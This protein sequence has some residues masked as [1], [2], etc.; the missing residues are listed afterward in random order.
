MSLNQALKEINSELEG[1]L[2]VSAKYLKDGREAEVNGSMLFPT[3]SV[4]KVPLLIE[5]YRQIEQ[6]QID[7]N[8]MVNLKEG[9]KVPGS[10]ILK[11]LEEGLSISVSDLSTLMMIVSD[12]TA[13]DI[14]LEKVGKDNVNKMLDEFGF[15]KT[16]VV[17]DCRD[18]LFDLVGL[19]D[20]PDK[21][22]TLKL[23]N[24]T[25]TIIEAKGSWS[26]GIDR[27]NVTTPVEMTRLLELIVK[28]EAAS[29]D[30]CNA[31]LD[32]MSKCQTGQYRIPKYLPSRDVKIIHKTGSLPGIRNDVGIVSR[33]DDAEG[34]IISCFTKNAGDV[35]S[36]EEAIAKASLQ[37]FERMP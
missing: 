8:E 2:G 33:V 11:E 3:A 13:T 1:H 31:I 27:N 24:E 7:L 21:R 10:G 15:K 9:H 18:I 16:R 23:Y 34:Y 25:V 20:L 4:F 19:N 30:S 35:Y 28:N 29:V 6:G 14:L 26:L 22:K 36:A 37:V 32:T 17:V 5:M 12:N